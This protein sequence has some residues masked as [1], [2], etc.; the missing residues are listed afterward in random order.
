MPLTAP[1]LKTSPVQKRELEVIAR[2]TT[3]P[4]QTVRRAHALLMAAGGMSNVEIARRCG[5]TPRTVSTW[6]ERFAVEGT[7]AVRR[8]GRDQSPPAVVPPRFLRGLLAQTPRDGGLVPPSAR[9][10]DGMTA[11][12]PPLRHLLPRALGQAPGEPLTAAG[13]YQGPEQHA[14]ALRE[15][16]GNPLH[17]ATSCRTHNDYLSFL[18]VLDW[19]V[20]QGEPVHLLLDRIS[21]Q[22]AHYTVERWLA[23]PRRARFHTYVIPG[24]DLWIE[25]ATVVLDAAGR[26]RDEGAGARR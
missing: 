8:A 7:G 19:H 5:V 16:G 20:P 2:S 10:L 15:T 12:P 4:T 26:A 25:L 9:A 6:R 1:P 17:T 13:L 24:P 11:A 21:P 18:R 23:N 14:L 22:V 3:S